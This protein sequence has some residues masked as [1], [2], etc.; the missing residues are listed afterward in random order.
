M[1]TTVDSEDMSHTHNNPLFGMS[2]SQSEIYNFEHDDLKRARQKRPWCLTVIVVYL[3][4]QTALNIFL[5]YKVFSFEQSVSSPQWSSRT[6]PQMSEGPADFQTLVK[7]NTEETHSL[8]RQLW[9]LKNQVESRCGEEGQIQRLQTDLVQLNSSA[10]RLDTRLSAI[11]LTQGHPGFPG[12]PGPKGNK[13]DGGSTGTKGEPGQ[14][15]EPGP[16]GPTGPTGPAGDQGPGAK[17]EPGLIGPAG[18]KG[19]SG[20][21][22]NPGSDG[23]QGEKGEKGDTGE[24]G[25][26][27]AQGVAGPPGDQGP[28][29][30]PGEKGSAG[31][32]PPDRNVRLVPGPTRGRVEVR[33][34]GVWG[35]VCDDNFDTVDAKVICKMLGHQTALA[36]FTAPPGTGRIWLDELRCTGREDDIF[37]CPHSGLGVNNCDHNEDVGVQCI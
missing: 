25:P 6:S 22:G 10:E 4:L 29:G 5:L 35:T 37:N 13:G 9:T 32:V 36:T 27:G 20:E 15:G 11:S 24:T 17:G 3:I 19:D 7:N 12:L 14:S 26:P 23:I 31:E 33:N 16:Q 21:K 18:P 8:R 2:L 1:D 30:P 34:N 28:P